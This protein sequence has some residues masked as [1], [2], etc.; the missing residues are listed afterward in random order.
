MTTQRT[1]LTLLLCII[2]NVCIIHVRADDDEEEVRFAWIGGSNHAEPYAVY[3]ELGVH[4]PTN[5]PGARYGAVGW[6][7]SASEELWVFGGYGYSSSRVG[8]SLLLST[9]SYLHQNQTLDRLFE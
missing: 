5:K 9:S 3:G 6:Y 2:F 8:S 7:D 1:S 4:S